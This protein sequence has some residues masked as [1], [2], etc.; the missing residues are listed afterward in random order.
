MKN[1]TAMD[2]V[3]AIFLSALGAIIFGALFTPPVFW[4]L[5][6]LLGDVPWPFSRVYDRVA[7]L[8]V[9]LFLVYFKRHLSLKQ[10][11]NYFNEKGAK[12]A[13]SRVLVGVVFSLVAAT[14]ALILTVPD[15]PMRWVQRSTDYYMWKGLKLIP[16]AL[17]ISIIE[18]TIFRAIIFKQLSRKMKWP[19][20]AVLSSA[21][22]AVVHFVRPLKS[23]SYEG[24]SFFAGFDYLLAVSERLVFPGI[25]P[26]MFGLFLVGIVLCY[27]LRSTGS[28]YLCIGLHSG[29][30]MVMKIAVYTTEAIPGGVFPEGSGRRYFL[31][32]QPEAW[33]SIGVV[34]LLVYLLRKVLTTNAV[35]N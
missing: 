27:T 35:A 30:V 21:L 29:W 1:S 16:A 26:A 17:V 32:T 8:G 2:L 24:F 5:A 7:L 3:R 14:I 20:A 31:L 15:S 6:K 33:I 23:Y 4:L 13:A 12:S 9:L 19:V 18:E 11:S 34:W 25:L 28:L 22:Y 10:L